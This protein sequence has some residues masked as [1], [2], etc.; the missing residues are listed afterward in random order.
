MTVSRYIRMLAPL[1][2][3]SFLAAGSVYA[4]ETRLVRV[5]VYS[6][7]PKLLMDEQGNPSGIL[8]ELLIRIAEE[9]NWQLQPLA[10]DWHQCL[11]MLEAGELDL[12]PDVARSR[13][14]DAR[15]DFH[16]EP[17]LNSWSKVYVP[18]G[19]QLE[20]PLALDG[21]RLAVLE[22]SIQ[23]RYL[24]DMAQ[25]FN[26]QPDFVPV[27]NYDAAF[28]A[29]QQGDAD[30]AV[31][32]HFFG[33]Y[34]A[35][36]FSLE[37]TSLLFQPSQLYYATGEGHNADLLQR[38]DRWLSVWRSDTRSVFYDILHR[39]AGTERMSEWPHWL[40]PSLVGLVL[41]LAVMGAFMVLL[42][43]QVRARTQAL[44]TRET[45]L[46]G[47]L[48]GVDACIYNKDADLRYTYVNPVL[49][50][51]LAHDETDIQG[52]TDARFFDSEDCRLL[53]AHDREVLESGERRVHEEELYSP[54]HGERRCYLSVRVPL[55]RPD[56]R[57]WGICGVS[58]DITEQR[59]QQARIHQ[60]SWYDSLTRLPNRRYL[61][62]QLEQART[63]AEEASSDG[64]VLLLDLD[65]FRDLNDALG[66]AAGDELL[67]Q[68]ASRLTD[69]LSDQIILGRLGGD[70][71]LLVQQGLSTD[72]K[73]A[74]QTV[75]GLCKRVLA[76]LK[77]PFM[78][79]AHRHRGGARIGV[80]LFSDLDASAEGLVR[81][82]ELAMYDS[83][84]SGE[85]R[86]RFFDPSMQAEVQQRA[87]LEAGIRAGLERNEFTLWYQP[88][89][90][91]YRTLLGLE[92]LVRWHHPEK[93]LVSPAEFIPVAESTGLIIPLGEQLLEQ[94]CRQL[95][96]WAEHPQL[97][98]AR[99]A[100]NISA[101]Q[102]HTP[103]FVERVS[104][105]LERTGAEPSRLELEVTESMLVQD[106]DNTIDKMRRL[107]RLGVRFS[108][109][110]FG[111][112]YSS[113]IFLKQLPLDKLKIDQGFVFELLTD[114][115]DAAIVRAIVALGQNLELAVIAEGVET[116]EHC[117]TLEAMGCH[118]YQGYFFSKPLPA[119]ELE[120]WLLTSAPAAT[121]P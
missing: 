94:A 71:F 77:E 108:L 87:E 18:A 5:G 109:D 14:R 40:M 52:Q 56:G 111:T 79:S 1:L 46:Q 63:R 100:V 6:N 105:I 76:L 113:L 97:S 89:Y 25:G 61:L 118:E 85:E 4:D 33:E 28:S 115:N 34:H 49:C 93:G 17:A 23:L 21:I 64:A 15:F 13:E 75:E 102:I 9:E 2:A 101:R 36:R 98:Q 59:Q 26:I 103:D 58:T 12:L 81:C 3:L 66:Y 44:A 73:Q 72:R 91:R 112:G 22:S 70:E 68:V 110:D 19:R 57:V 65:H 62:Q 120:R 55:S 69:R 31:A 10:C 38:I 51:T 121:E 96:A 32:N 90:D 29:V 86:F 99:V 116:L 41:A 48:A 60:L 11:K 37:G 82:A 114:A 39:W 35:Q 54:L 117:H 95:V 27:R 20:S 16:T 83:H 7:P 43:I 106:V 42:R 78:L 30:A 119:D 24:Q 104:A 8:G 67:R 107:R 74:M 53:H 88:Q 45:Q 92:A 84:A 80:S 50:R 47:V